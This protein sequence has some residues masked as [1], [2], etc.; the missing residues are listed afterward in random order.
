M[1]FDFE[2]A[3]YIGVVCA[4]KD[5]VSTGQLKDVLQFFA[6]KRIKYSVLGYFDGKKIPENFLY[7]KGMDFITQKDLNF[8][9]IPVGPVVDNFIND[10]F[11]M[12]INCSVENFFPI[13]YMVQLSKA[14]CKVGVLHDKSSCYDLMID[15]SKQKTVG[16]FIENL[17]I[18]LSHLR[19]SELS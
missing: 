8:F 10:P 6:Q 18:Y 17:K 7:W 2:T 12:L 15:I 4:T 14:K 19:H 16:Y 9:C 13:E 11:D 5:E 1:L 3:K